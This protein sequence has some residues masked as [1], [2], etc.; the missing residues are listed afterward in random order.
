MAELR[1]YQPSFT[2][3]ELS[4]ALGARVDL[5]KYSSGLRTA[6][7]LFIHP[8]GGASN[9]AGTEFVTEVKNSVHATRKI[10]FEFNTEQTYRL[11]FGDKYFRVIRD[12]ALIV[13][14][15]YPYEVATPYGYADVYDIVYAQDADVMYLCHAD[16]PVQKISRLAEDN[17][18][19]DP[20]TFAP[21]TA[22][23][24]GVGG[25][26]LFNRRKGTTDTI[27]YGV[28][29]V[30]A[31]GAQSAISATVGVAVQHENEDGR[32]VRVTWNAVAGAAIYRVYRVGGTNGGVLVETT[33]TTA[34][35]SQMTIFGDGATAPSTPDAGAP[36]TPTG[37]NAFTIY[38]KVMTYVVS[39]INADTG[40]ES[41]PSTA[42]ALIND[43]SYK[44]NRNI[45]TW[46]AVAGASAYLIYKSDNGLYGYIGRS[47]TTTFVDENIV[48][49]ISN[50]PQQAR[51][52]FASAGNY[53]RVATF[54]EQ[55]LGLFSTKNDP[56]ASFLSQTANYENFG[57]SSPAKASDAVTF[58]IKSRQV[59]AIRA[60]IA[61]RGLML[62]T[63]GAEWT[64]SGG[65]QSDAITPSAQKI[66]NE[67]YRGSARVQP[68]VVGNT[69]LFAQG[70]GGVIRD[71]SY[72][73]ASNGYD[74]KDLTILARHLFEDREIV[75]WA[76]AQAPY[77]IAWVVLD[78]GM[79]CSLTYL[80]EHDVWAWTR[81]E[82]G[83]NGEAIFEDVT[84]AREG[85]E[86]VPY[87]MVNRMIGNQSKRYIERLHSRSFKTIE[88]AF[89][90]DCGLT[91]SGAPAK[92]ITGL[93]H[94]LGQTV[95]ALADGNV[96]RNLVVGPVAGGI[97]VKL[98]Y[99]ASKVHVG[100]PMT[101]TLETLNLD[102]GS[103]QG[104]G[105][106]QGREKSVSNLTM[107][108]EKTR[109]IFIGPYDGDR[110]SEHLV[111][112]KQRDNEAWKEPIQLYTGDI[113][114]TPDWDWNTNGRM[115]VKQFD[116][117]PMTIL[118]LMPD[119]TVGR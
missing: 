9:R 110:D 34:D 11:E 73:F 69:V 32:M 89:F 118:A 113:R 66:D 60:A 62:L 7:N 105:T 12:G 119:V 85:R 39:A 87:F 86:D 5:A 98:P 107:R 47:Q 76:Y 6:V 106:V 102:L 56:Q 116:P 79:L 80:K 96:V 77:S 55:R 115:F 27:T 101:A 92:I 48:A 19:I 54:I 75:S 28:T 17:W 45:V 15:G 65:S 8:H 33:E 46:N 52:P 108:V 112:Y 114:I 104:L 63:S 35:I 41:L 78:N 21:K 70:T 14:D 13:K 64:I 68:I 100:L 61:L 93:D 43:L 91:Y 67:G 57:V 24:T 40:E 20:V 90:V 94:L 53:P 74:G 23:P 38:G 50:G 49:D 95:V 84:V 16:Y 58:R 111:E 83:P 51:N 1:A 25:S 22:R 82:S 30:S 81:H 44:G 117:L 42:Y 37:F 31:S 2:A 109:G 71:F 26:A 18:S 103:V 97:G 36:G 4:P 59:N 3:G 72:D 99:A 10:P 88:D 29:A